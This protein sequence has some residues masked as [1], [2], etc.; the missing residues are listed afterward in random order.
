MT[1]WRNASVGIMLG[2]ILYV[3][4]ASTACR[5][6]DS[7][8]SQH[9]PVTLAST[10]RV[11]P[12]TDDN[13]ASLKQS[14]KRLQ[15]L[16]LVTQETIFER[17]ALSSEDKKNL[18]VAARLRMPGVKIEQSCLKVTGAGCSRWSLDPFVRSLSQ[19]RDGQKTTRV[20]VF[21]NSLI[22]SDHI[23]DIVREAFVAQFG[24]GGRGFL[25]A[26]RMAEYGRRTRTGITRRGFATYNFGQGDIGP[27]PH[28]LPGVLHETQQKAST[29]WLIKGSSQA[30][31]FWY[32]HKRA[33]AFSLWVD[34][35]KL[36][37]VEPKGEGKGRVEIMALPDGAKNLVFKTKK[38]RSVL[39]GV[40]LEKEQPGFI[41]DTFGV[42]ASDATR[43]LK[44]NEDLH[45][46]QLSALNPDLVVFMLGGNEIKRV[47]WGRYGLKTVR[48]DLRKLIR[49]TKDI[50]PQS[51]CLVIGPLENVRGLKHKRPFQTRPQVR[52]VNAA[53][54]DVALEEGCAF[55]DLFKAMGGS[56]AMKR[57]SK[58]NLLHDDL[59]HPKGRGLDIPG[60][61][62]VDSLFKTMSEP[63]I[64]QS[65]LEEQWNALTGATIVPKPK[66]ERSS[67]M[68][69]VV[70]LGQSSAV[71]I[72][73]FHD[74]S[75]TFFKS[76]EGTGQFF[77]QSFIEYY[78]RLKSFK[79]MR[80]AKSKKGAGLVV[81]QKLLKSQDGGESDSK[82]AQ[83]G[84]SKTDLMI[85][86][87]PSSLSS[88]FVQESSCLVIHMN[89]ALKNEA[90]N[91]GCMYFEVTTALG[92]QA[93]LVGASLVD[94]GSQELNAKGESL[95]AQMVWADMLQ[96]VKMK[97]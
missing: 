9:K 80:P 63:L 38:R 12:N 37:D 92:G 10:K 34:G 2:M 22:A 21:G 46:E 85:Y 77:L 61:L 18:K 64:K 28:G 97:Q 62:I 82:G 36:K 94:N 79:N 24:D 54:R 31:L 8:N 45:R 44:T 13:S 93:D 40:S 73:P 87:M 14:R 52:L 47:A 69:S 42:V 58:N 30:R 41:L 15:A 70:Q 91:H 35:E 86:W 48:D 71:D 74:A 20:A 25:L 95:V 56:G 59:V 1:K 27:Y 3:L 83:V 51:A 78:E 7:S 89:G 19:T 39:Y 16:E 67:W 53:K 84:L 76:K 81:H 96:A 32:D 66:P 90:K 65:E 26:D 68:N 60:S 17:L 43:F 29:R 88:P 33:P 72:D 55:M 5:A 50:A 23:V 11:A 49:R 75:V 57:L 6:E 4:T